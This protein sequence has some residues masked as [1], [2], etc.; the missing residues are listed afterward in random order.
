MKSKMDVKRMSFGRGEICNAYYA[1]LDSPLNLDS[2]L[3]RECTM[4]AAK[5]K[6]CR[7]LIKDEKMRFN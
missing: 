5:L 4:K 3:S 1:Q 7:G 2:G 6:T